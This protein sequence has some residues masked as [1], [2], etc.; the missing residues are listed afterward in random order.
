MP[1]SLVRRGSSAVSRLAGSAADAPLL[2]AELLAWRLLLPVLKRTMSIGLLTRLMWSRPGKASADADARVRSVL[3]R[4]GRALLS[5]NC[6]ERSLVLYRV[7]SRLGMSPVMLLGTRRSGDERLD[8]H[9]W[10]EIGGRP[11][12]ESDASD[13]AALV[14]FG[15]GGAPLSSDGS[16]AA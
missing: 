1:V 4:G 3:E 11:F 5:A 13:Y 6:V 9:A 7:F 15:T 16:G 14:M 12:G 8:G 2:V 10:V